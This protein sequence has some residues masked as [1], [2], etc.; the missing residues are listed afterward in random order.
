MSYIL[1]CY[2]IPE[3]LKGAALVGGWHFGDRDAMQAPCH[4][5][6]P[7]VEEYGFCTSGKNAFGC[8]P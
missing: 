1:K 2:E 8:M 5:D 3:V 4:W 7:N 6:V